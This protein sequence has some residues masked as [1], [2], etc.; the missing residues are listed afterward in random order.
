MKDEIL[1]GR[2]ENYNNLYSDF[3]KNKMIE[4]QNNFNLT[5]RKNKLLKSIQKKR[6]DK[7]EK[8]LDLNLNNE[9]FINIS[10]NINQLKKDLNSNDNHLITRALFQIR[11]F[12][13]ESDLKD[14]KEI[15]FF[16]QNFFEEI[17]KILLLKNYSYSNLIIITFINIFAN[18]I[19]IIVKIES[20]YKLQLI[21]DEYLSIYK[22]LIN[23]KIEELSGNLFWFLSNLFLNQ[24]LLCYNILEKT[25]FIQ[26]ITSSLKTK[27]PKIFSN[28]INCLFSICNIKNYNL[29]SQLSEEK[30]NNLIHITSNLIEVFRYK[31][32]DENIELSNKI[33]ILDTLYNIIEIQRKN[34]IYE[35]LSTP[36]YNF[37]LYFI[38]YLQYNMITY[39]KY[40]NFIYYSIK[41]LY[42]LIRNGNYS[43]INEILSFNLLELFS[44]IYKNK[45]CLKFL[46]NEI[47]SYI[48]ITIQNICEFRYEFCL[49]ILNNEIFNIIIDDMK[50]N[51]N[52]K[53][54]NLHCL[55]II[56][57]ILSY[58]KKDANDYIISKNI[59][60]DYIYPIFNEYYQDIDFLSVIIHIFHYLLEFNIYSDIYNDEIS[61]IRELYNIILEKIQFSIPPQLYTML[62]KDTIQK[63]NKLK[64]SFSYE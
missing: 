21:N 17:T 48:L 52:I 16:F 4:R 46:T 30:I 64:I 36:N 42:A 37:V 26:T 8:N 56:S 10:S 6:F 7:K 27:F 62:K 58:Q 38:Q 39:F 63:E 9:I 31:N 35:I 32:Y 47:I 40:S 2:N 57:D 45:K 5:L 33:T 51:N 3:S 43:S 19:E 22:N 61:K 53:E 24:D 54:I 28:A 50:K 41:F 29:I 13:Q 25:D 59:I 44:I 18:K 49:V 1:V 12:F 55:K 15:N 14:E 60:F 11:D 34:E 23:E 20:K